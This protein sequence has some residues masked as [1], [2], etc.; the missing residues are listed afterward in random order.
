I[1]GAVDAVDRAAEI[2]GAR[3]ERIGRPAGDEARQIGLAL[4]HLRRRGPIR[5]LRLA[6]DALDAG[7]G[8][9][10]AADADAVAHRLAV[11]EHEVKIRVRR[12]DDDGARR[13]AGAIV[14]DLAAQHAAHLA[15]VVAR[16]GVGGRADRRPQRP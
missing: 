13:L 10:L 8:E 6:L 2:H 14:D 9:A 16:I 11:A 5:P 4:D 7:P 3:A 12:I 15:L 1:V